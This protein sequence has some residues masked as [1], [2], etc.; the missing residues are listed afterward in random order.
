MVAVVSPEC[1]RHARPPR[2]ADSHGVQSTAAVVLLRP[3]AAPAAPLTSSPAVRRPV[4]LPVGTYRRRRAVAA[5]LVAVVV[6]ALSAALGTLGGG[7]LPVPERPA[8]AGLTG[9]AD[10]PVYI[11]QPGDTFWS[12][13][14]RLDPGGDPR[15]VVD[16]LV[17]AHGGATL[18]VG[19]RLPL[20]SR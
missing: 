2:S 13:A 6:L 20:P 5:G 8:R 1:R 18:H 15:P 16:R 10:G 14:R 12:I 11:V 19:E 7:P 3:E 17:A 9:V 4:R